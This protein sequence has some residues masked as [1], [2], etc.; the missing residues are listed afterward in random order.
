[1]IKR[2]KSKFSTTK[3]VHIIKSY[4]NKFYASNHQLSVKVCL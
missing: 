4:A 1:M 2:D 3:K